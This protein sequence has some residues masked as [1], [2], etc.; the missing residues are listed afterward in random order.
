MSRGLCRDPLLFSWPFGRSFGPTGALEQHL[1]PAGALRGA[2]KVGPSGPP[3]GEALT[4]P[5]LGYRQPQLQP[6]PLWGSLDAFLGGHSS[7]LTIARELGEQAVGFGCRTFLRPVA[8]P[9]GA[10]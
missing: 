3:V 6:G 7:D 10:W 8:L 1:A 5:C 2:V 9:L 4:G